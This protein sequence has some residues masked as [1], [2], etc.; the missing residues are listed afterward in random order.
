MKGEDEVVEEVTK[1]EVEGAKVIRII[2]KFV[3]DMVLQDEE[4]TQV[5]EEGFI[6]GL[7]EDLKDQRSAL[8]ERYS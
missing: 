4:D 5:L 1:E 2:T 7:V 3:I 8:I 6:K